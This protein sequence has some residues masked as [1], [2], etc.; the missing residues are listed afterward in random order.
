MKA[1]VDELTLEKKRLTGELVSARE[2][3]S[4]LKEKLTFAERNLERAEADRARLKGELCL[5]WKQ[6]STH[7][8]NWIHAE[9]NAEAADIRSKGLA[10]D[11]ATVRSEAMRCQKVCQSQITAME[12]D[13]RNL[14]VD[15]ARLD[16]T[17][18]TREIQLARS[19]QTECSLREENSA[20]RAKIED[21]KEKESMKKAADRHHQVC[22]RSSV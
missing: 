4:A 12:T 2:G 3:R 15:Y 18:D 20:L 7:E 1:A 9:H 8:K 5:C 21:L 10:D 16:R 14:K 17:L 13:Q 11:L 6:R 19:Q 22:E